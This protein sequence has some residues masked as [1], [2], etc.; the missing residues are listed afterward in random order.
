VCRGTW[1]PWTWR[2]C[3]KGASFKGRCRWFRPGRACRR[4]L[5]PPGFRQWRIQVRASE[6]SLR[7]INRRQRA[8]HSSSMPRRFSKWSSTAI[9]R[10]P[11]E[12]LWQPKLSRTRGW[13]DPRE[14][15]HERLRPT[16]MRPPVQPMGDLL[17]E[18]GLPQRVPS[19]AVPDGRVSAEALHRLHRPLLASAQRVEARIPQSE[20]LE[21]SP[22]SPPRRPAGARQRH[23]VGSG[24][25]LP[26]HGP[27]LL[28]EKPRRAAIS[29][30]HVKRQRPSSSVQLRREETML[31][32]SPAIGR[33]SPGKRR[34]SLARLR[35]A[36]RLGLD[37]AGSPEPS[38]PRA[39]SG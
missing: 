31:P 38:R 12:Q 24:L 5:A 15:R 18:K 19:Q 4:E 26:T 29:L 35:R 8:A 16:P 10:S 27:R 14:R 23:R 11:A 28:P 2:G 13:A 39:V 33:D 34:Q 30:R 25:I 1:E 22:L 21:R 6:R 9:R 20:G 32:L 37:G 7:E 36:R 17:R 3:G